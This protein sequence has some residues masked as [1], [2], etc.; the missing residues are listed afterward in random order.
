MTATQPDAAA[1]T[2][3]R[4]SSSSSAPGAL[5]GGAAAVTAARAVAILG[6]A[7]ESK[8]ASFR[9]ARAALAADRLPTCGSV[10]RHLCAGDWTSG[11]SA[12]EQQQQQIDMRFP[13]AAALLEGW[14]QQQLHLEEEILPWDKKHYTSRSEWPSREIAMF[15]SK[16][17]LLWLE[18]IGICTLQ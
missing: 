8:L 3:S 9:R 6:A 10:L 15:G 4:A 13:S 16:H 18:S 12:S 14:Q 2:G 11:R 1:G 5:A 7:G 17:G